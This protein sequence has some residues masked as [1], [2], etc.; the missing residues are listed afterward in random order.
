[1]AALI[2][3][4]VLAPFTPGG[5]VAIFPHNQIPKPRLFGAA[6]G[7]AALWGGGWLRGAVDDGYATRWLVLLCGVFGPLR[8]RPDQA[9]LGGSWADCCLALFIPLPCRRSAVRAGVSCGRVAARPNSRAA[10]RG[11]RLVGGAGWQSGP[12][13]GTGPWMRW[14]AKTNSGKWID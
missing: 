12:A 5:V 1:M 3:G 7:L 14:F 13:D 6:A 11:E 9:K 2:A 10:V 4:L 8:L